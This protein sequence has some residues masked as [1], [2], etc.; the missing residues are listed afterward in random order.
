MPI[1]FFICCAYNL[2]NLLNHIKINK[3]FENVQSYTIA[4]T[5]SY[6][7]NIQVLILID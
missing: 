7:P 1:D 6:L 2:S 4:H 3:T 5:N